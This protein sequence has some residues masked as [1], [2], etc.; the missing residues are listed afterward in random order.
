M[1][2]NFTGSKKVFPTTVCYHNKNS[3][4]TADI[5]LSQN[6]CG[7]TSL[8]CFS[9]SQFGVFQAMHFSNHLS[10]DGFLLHPL[11]FFVFPKHISVYQLLFFFF[12]FYSSYSSHTRIFSTS[13][14]SNEYLNVQN[15][16]TLNFF[17]SFSV[18]NLYV[19]H[20]F[21]SLLAMYMVQL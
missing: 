6:S 5:R 4:R 20:P 14:F 2:F 3:D 10:G 13:Y 7:I 21:L 16:S 1:G 18:P 9:P 8:F 11:C 19:R 12:Y 17:M 15:A